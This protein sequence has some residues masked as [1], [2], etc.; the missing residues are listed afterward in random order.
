MNSGNMKCKRSISLDLAWSN[1]L[2]KLPLGEKQS[3]L[4]ICKVDELPV[5]CSMKTFYMFKWLW[6]KSTVSPL[7]KG[8][9]T[10]LCPGIST[11]I[12]NCVMQ[13][14]LNSKNL[15]FFIP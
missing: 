10:L 9:N 13:Q 12:E 8:L 7:L 2:Y 15:T 1:E 3:P 6:G 5:R 11:Y 14:Q 4:Y